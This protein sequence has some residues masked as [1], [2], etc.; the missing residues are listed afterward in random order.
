[1][2]GI[3]GCWIKDLDL[4]FRVVVIQSDQLLVSRGWKM[5]TIISSFRFR[6]YDSMCGVMGTEWRNRSLGK[7]FVQKTVTRVLVRGPS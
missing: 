7:G 1:M 4:G 6:V 5:E 3:E 2:F